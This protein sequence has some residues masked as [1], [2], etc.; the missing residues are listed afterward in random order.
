MAK[1]LVGP[2]ERHVEKVVV[3]VA[4][5]FL[6]GVLALYLVSSPNK[7]Q[8]GGTDPVAPSGIDALLAQKANQVRE[9]IKAAKGKVE[10]P[11]PVAEAFAAALDPFKA[12][13][14]GAPFA[15]GAALGPIVPIIDA[16][17]VIEG[18]AKLVDVLALP[19]PQVIFG[20][21]TVLANNDATAVNWVT[22][23]SMFDVKKQIEAQ[24]LAYGETR[25]D[26]IYASGDLQRRSQRPDGSWSDD[27]WQDV[28]SWPAFE[29]PA[30]PELA[31]EGEGKKIGM[32]KE[33]MDALQRFRDNIQ[34]SGRQ[35]SILRPL[36]IEVL[37]G[38]KWSLPK[39]VPYRQLLVFDDEIRSPQ[40][41]SET[42]E[43][44]YG[45]ATGEPVAAGAEVPAG[46]EVEIELKAAQKM[47]ASASTDAE[48]IEVFNRAAAILTN[49][50][51]SAENK[52]KAR[53]LQDEADQ[54]QRDIK[55]RGGP[56]VPAGGGNVPN[57]PRTPSGQQVVW[58]HDAAPDSLPSGR[59][60]QYRIRMTLLN[61]LAGEPLLLRNKEDATQVFVHGSWSEPGDP[62]EIPATERFFIT[63]CDERKQEVTAEMYRW[64]D[65][66][67]VKART[68]FGMGQ[69]LSVTARTPAPSQ[70]NP[71]EAD[72]PEVEFV[73]DA[74]LMDIDFK[75]TFREQKKG[76]GKGGVKYPAAVADCG[77]VLVDQDGRLEERVVATDKNH[78]DKKILD[79]RIWRAPK[80]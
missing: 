71:L 33:N 63:A 3:A 55:R 40:F 21:S 72:N 39:W 53:K 80:P 64:F 25:K 75:R 10:T 16:P 77:V 30:V 8:I 5:L 45:M 36:F 9:Q 34:D 26:L 20:R 52:T 49:P 43:D 15:R 48:C 76:S 31:L 29:M 66:V 51:A 7:I 73:A 12:E 2:V 61:R 62:I 57:K 14:L 27:D 50:S 56:A 58:A 17:T 4:G 78:P 46:N 32:S 37:N 13:K 74:T 18:S 23:S 38:D 59:T 60:V 68:K 79:E 6:I 69:P 41:E 67:W 65:G 22:V 19:K 44:R 1:Q 28:I 70:D 54:K 42:L 35:I 11:E 47:L 24:G